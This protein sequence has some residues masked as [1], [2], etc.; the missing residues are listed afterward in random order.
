MQDPEYL[1]AT[2]L[3]RLAWNKGKLVG[4]KPQLRPKHV[5]RVRVPV[6]RSGPKNESAYRGS[7]V[8]ISFLKIVAP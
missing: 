3:R 1:S 8:G 6:A 4:A 7:R 2:P 5:F